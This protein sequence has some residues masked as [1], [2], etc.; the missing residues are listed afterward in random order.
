VKQAATI[1]CP[2]EVEGP[3][4]ESERK[5]KPSP[6]KPKQQPPYAVVLLD[7]DDHSFQFV[8]ETLMM[9]RYRSSTRQQGIRISARINQQPSLARRASMAHFQCEDQ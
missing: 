5:Q 9:E 4:A 7:D 2:P 1:E 8:V 6:G 3:E